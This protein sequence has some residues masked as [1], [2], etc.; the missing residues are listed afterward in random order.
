MNNQDNSVPNS[1]T[2]IEARIVAAGKTAPRVTPALID[3]L[4]VDA[5]Y[6]RGVH[7]ITG[8][9]HH[10]E[11]SGLNEGVI[12]DSIDTHTFC[13]L[14]LKNGFIVTGESNCADPSNFDAAIGRDIAYRN[15]RD[16]IWSLEG[17]RLRSELVGGK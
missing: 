7:A 11:Y 1:E 16:K 4:I 17:Y 9:F 8:T 5:F 2:E 13:M 15:A 10:F 6:F 12:P 3:S 14:V